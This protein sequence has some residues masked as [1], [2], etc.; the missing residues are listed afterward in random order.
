MIPGGD[1]ALTKGTR[2]RLTRDLVRTLTQA[3][4]AGEDH[5]I[6]D[7][8]HVG[9]SGDVVLDLKRGGRILS[10]LGDNEEDLRPR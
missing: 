5:V 4:S 2:V 7:G 1:I 3:L 6:F 10:E 8:G 9:E